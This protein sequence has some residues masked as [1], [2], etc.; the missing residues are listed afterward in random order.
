MV[1][2]DSVPEL[3]LWMGH[4]IKAWFVLV[5]IFVIFHPVVYLWLPCRH[6]V[7]H[8]LASELAPASPALISSCP[9]LIWNERKINYNMNPCNLINV[10]NCFYAFFFLFVHWKQIDCK[11]LCQKRGQY[12]RLPNFAGPIFVSKARNVNSICWPCVRPFL[13][14]HSGITR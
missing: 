1:Y 4:F 12:P 7:L 13:G 3:L 9:H 5:I 10:N 8:D 11:F 6:G 2:N 14:W